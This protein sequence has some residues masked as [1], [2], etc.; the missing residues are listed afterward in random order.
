MR[1]Q[2]VHVVVA[3]ACTKEMSGWGPDDPGFVWS[4][5]PPGPFCTHGYEKEY[6]GWQT[7]EH[8]HGGTTGWGV[9]SSSFVGCTG[10]NGMGSGW[11]CG[12]WYVHDKTTICH[13]G[14]KHPDPAVV[15]REKALSD[16]F[17][18]MSQQ[19]VDETAPGR[20]AGFLK[21]GQ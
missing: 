8:F 21:L 18:N 20:A 4:K 9:P 5:S 14:C 7:C 10:P 6:C 3:S 16:A 17:W 13:E 12:L 11:R 19:E 2:K 15:A 1:N